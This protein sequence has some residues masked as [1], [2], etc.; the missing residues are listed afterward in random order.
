MLESDAGHAVS[1]V[2]RHLAAVFFLCLEEQQESWP[3]D[4]ACQCS[5]KIESDLQHGELAFVINIKPSSMT[6]FKYCPIRINANS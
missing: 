2:R 5:N 1:G 3:Q 4:V 6:P